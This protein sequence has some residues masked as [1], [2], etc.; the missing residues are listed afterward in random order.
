MGLFLVHTVKCIK[1]QLDPDPALAI[2]HRGG[3]RV[4]HALAGVSYEAVAVALRVFLLELDEGGLFLVLG[5]AVHLE[6]CAVLLQ[7]FN[8][9]FQASK[10][11]TLLGCIRCYLQICLH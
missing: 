4:F 2:A 3:T 1:L 11:L 6:V 8:H 5:H 9:L 10:C 7:A